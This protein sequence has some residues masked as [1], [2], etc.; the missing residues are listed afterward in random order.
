MRKFALAIALI[1]ILGML[2]ACSSG[3]SEEA[4]EE[5]TGVTY[6]TMSMDANAEAAAAALPAHVEEY[7]AYAVEDGEVEGEEYLDVTGV[8]PVFVGYEVV[9]WEETG[10]E[11]DVEYVEV[12]YING[13]IVSSYASPETEMTSEPS[14]ITYDRLNVREMPP[15]PS[16][17]ELAAV[18]AAEA[19][20]AEFFPDLSATQYGIKRYLF[21]YEKDGMGLVVGMTADGDLGSNSEPVDLKM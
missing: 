11:R 17:R 3:D 16:E 15:N 19:K 6:E 8:E 1:L 18:A 5:D 13:Q 14:I 21:L 9:A 4:A 12:S 7:V 20:L 10:D 2:G